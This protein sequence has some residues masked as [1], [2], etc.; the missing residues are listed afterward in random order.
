MIQ[1]SKTNIVGEFREENEVQLKNT[2][3]LQRMDQN[4][5]VLMEK[6]TDFEL[7]LNYVLLRRTKIKKKMKRELQVDAIDQR[8]PQ[9]YQQILT[10][11]SKRFRAAFIY[12]SL[13]LILICAALSVI[14]EIIVVDDI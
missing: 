6:M 2:M 13:I 12:F 7:K 14:F 1:A 10:N 5:E 11:N 3:T 8:F 4:L 9:A